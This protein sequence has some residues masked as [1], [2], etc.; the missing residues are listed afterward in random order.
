LPRGERRELHRRVAEWVQGVAPDRDVETSELAAYHYREAVAYGEDD[1]DVVR[2]A[3][4]LLLAAGKSAMHRGAFVAARAQMEHAVALAVEDADRASALLAL[5][6]VDGTEARWDV[7]IQ[8]LETAES[9]VAVENPELRSAVLALRSRLFWMTG[10][11]EEAL[12]AAN[13]AVSALAGL[14]ESDQLARALARRSQIE[15]LKNQPDAIEHSRESIAVAD[16]VGDVFAGVNA[17]INLFTAR[18]TEGEGPDPDE[19]L[20]IVEAAASVG[21]LEEAYRAIVNFVWSGGGYLPVDRIESVAAFAREG[22]LP[23]PPIIAAYLQLS[24]AGMLLVP[25]G[26]WPEADAILAS[27]DAPSLSATSRLLWYPT[28]GGLALRRG[29]EAAADD[30]LRD[31]RPLAMASGEPQRIVPMACAV[32]P[33]LLI[34]GE[35]DEL[36]SLAEE[37]V[38]VVDGRWPAVLSLDAVLRT[39]AAAGDLELLTATMESLRRS[40]GAEYAGRRGISLRTAEGLEA[41]AAGRVE[42][43][44][45]HLSPATARLDGLGLAYDGACSKLELA[46]ALERAGRS[47]EAEE[48][49]REAESVFA[50][51]GCVNPF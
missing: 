8:R 35:I 51:L 38:A 36:R 1:P 2:R 9:L 6:E 47:A 7:A 27:I 25:A 20:A 44:V 13:G 5:A 24:I 15:M 40:P 10:S 31:L 49:R 12:E 33:W 26:R 19:I 22:R 39:L 50:A 29:D 14:P 43:A 30:A 48:K 4:A 45:D 16:R 28:V 32:L 42:E 18:A 46:R 11:W 3:Y 23:P 34:S 21:A 37:L 41:L 17:R